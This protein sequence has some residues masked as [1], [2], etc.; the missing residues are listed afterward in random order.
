MAARDSGGDEWGVSVFHGDGVLVLRD[1]KCS[2]A[3]LHF[4]LNATEPHI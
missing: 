3:A 2:V 4:V 1:G